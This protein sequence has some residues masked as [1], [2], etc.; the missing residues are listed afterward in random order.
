MVL[1]VEIFEKETNHF[2]LRGIIE[3]TMKEFLIDCI[4][5]RFPNLIVEFLNSINFSYTYY[6]GTVAGAS[7]PIT[8]NEYCKTY[9]GSGCTCAFKD[10]NCTLKKG[11]LTNFEISTKVA[12]I[13]EFIIINHQDCGAFK[14]FLSKSGYP[15]TLGANNPKE[16]EVLTQSMLLTKTYLQK[17]Y[18]SIPAYLLYIIDINGWVAQYNEAESVWCV[19]YKNDNNDP[20]GLWYNYSLCV[21]SF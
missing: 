11:I 2:F 12:D 16:I 1:V 14:V 19:I 17:K 8:Y 15:L 4:D 18:P 7:L 13:E 3:G 10:T 6:Q 21:T 5:Y 20:R 9:P